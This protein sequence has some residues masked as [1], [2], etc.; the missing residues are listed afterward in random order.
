M[1]MKKLLLTIAATFG[2]TAL[3]MA[4][5]VPNYVPTNGLVGWWPFNGNAND[6]S[7]N[8]N[9]GAV[10][11][12]LL[13][14]DRFGNTNQAY[15][16]DGL[17]NVITVP[18]NNSL[19]F[20]S[21]NEYSVSYWIKPETIS[22]TQ[23]SVIISK[24]TGA[25]FDQDGW[26]SFIEPN[27]QLNFYVRNGI[28]QPYSGCNFGEINVE[29]NYHVIQTFESDSV[30]IYLNGI[31]QGSASSNGAIVG[32][33]SNPML[34]GKASWVSS[35]TTGYNGILDDIGIWNRALTQQEITDL[36]NA[37]SCANNTAVTPQTNSLPI[38][39]TA[40]F[41]AT[42]LDPNPTYVWQS[43]FGQDYVTL[44]DYGNYSG[45]NTG[46]LNI[47]NV[48]LPNH[49]QPIRVIT[50]SGNCIDTSNVAIIS[51][52]DTCINT[53]TDTTFITVTDTLLINTTITSLNPPNNAN[54]IKVF[55]NPTNDHITIDYGNFS[56]MNGY[57]LK[58]ENSLGQQ[59]FQTNITEQS[60]YLNL[61]TWGGNGLYFVHIIDPQGNTIDIR[62]IVLQ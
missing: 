1:K 54:A 30:K 9:N 44:N 41:N 29:N 16:F 4:Q 58:I 38:G 42:T 27:F 37:V 59:V 33:N 13:T 51:I 32:N 53:I 62:K 49:T 2:M 10:N 48:Q 21:V 17:N 3:T 43:D 47:A 34:F 6:E 28:G 55:P 11:G 5:N 12:A 22:S 39:S 61:T 52:S 46:T 25:G 24:Q 15:H 18:D 50:T 20:E 57:Q 35:N 19:N 45:T 8:G 31:L 14:T 56:V 7:G 36:Y 40:T 60:D 23:A 26:N